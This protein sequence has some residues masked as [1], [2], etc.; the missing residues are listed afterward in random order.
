MAAPRL[1]AGLDM[2]KTQVMNWVN[3]LLSTAP[4][5][6]VEGQN[7][8]NTTD[9]HPYYH[10]GTSFKDL[11]DALTLAGQ[12]STYHLTRANHTGTQPSS[13]ITNFGSEVQTVIEAFAPP[14]NVSTLGGQF[15]S[16]NPKT[17]INADEFALSDTEDTYTLK[18]ITWA[19]IKALLKTYFDTLYPSTA[20][21]DATGGYA[22]LTLFKINFKN[23][24][25]TFTS[26]FTNANTAARTYTFADRDGTVADDTD[27]TAAKARASHTGTQSADSLTDGA[28]NKAFLA[29]ERT[30]LA[31]I[32]TAAT[33]NDTDANLKARANHTGTQ[34][35]ATIS[36]FD[37]QVRTSRLDQM[38]A[39]TADVS[40][41]SHKLTNVTNPSSAQDA[42]TK[43]YVD[44]IG[45]GGVAWKNSVRAATTAN[46]TLATA[47]ANGQTIDGV[48]L[49]TGDRILLKN[50]AT[51]A[52]NGIYTVQASGAPVRATDADSAGEI[53]GAAVWIEEGTV[54][55]DQAWVLTTNAPITLETT[56]LV[57]VQ[58]SGLGQITTG[59]G[60]TKTG[61]QIEVGAGTGITVNAD[62]VAIT[63]SLVPRMY[64]G[65]IGDNSAT[66]FTITAATL[67]L[68][69]G[70]KK[71][72]QVFDDSTG[73]WVLPDV[74]LSS[75]GDVV[76]AFAIAPTA[77]QYRA[78]ITGIV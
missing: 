21:K 65:T 30:K 28:T 55:G 10:N 25:N 53:R 1:V 11:T 26:F 29:T 61:N 27:I 5:A 52:E 22:G 32:A 36:D 57:F 63:T 58:F 38:A 73:E 72:V 68:G 9:H 19:N 37:T 74:T 42:A 43:A 20:N 54:N 49:V 7:Y 47:F 40:F 35:A 77:N 60:L 8:H 70:R 46:G 41:N 56:S 48:A 51:G 31:G 14:E 12:D 64:S 2:V 69:T 33:A 62:D 24:A 71:M 18:K 78:N 39:P 23:V 45:G 50:Q 44:G 4:S 15:N 75:N 16:A 59:N 34:T 17:P 3:H 67:G 66:S 76:I 13:S 6:P